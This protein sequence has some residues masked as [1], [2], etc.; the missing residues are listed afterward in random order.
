[1][2]AAHVSERKKFLDEALA[3]IRG[4]ERWDVRDAMI[5]AEY[6]RTGTIYEYPSPIYSTKDMTDV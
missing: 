3:L 5:I 2:S 1:M 4:D 6:L